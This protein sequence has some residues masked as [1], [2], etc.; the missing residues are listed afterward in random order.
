VS[1][2]GQEDANQN[3]VG[4]ACETAEPPEPLETVNVSEVSGNILVKLP[5]VQ[6]FVPLG[7][8][9]Q[10]PL[11]STIDARNGK[12]RLF[13]ARGGGVGRVVPGIGPA[14]AGGLE[15]QSA[16]FGSGMFKVGQQQ[17][18]AKLITRI[19]LTGGNFSQCRSGGTSPVKRVRRIQAVGEGSFSTK[20]R[21]GTATASSSTATT[22]WNTVDQCNGTLVKA[23]EGRLVVH[24][25]ARDRTIRLKAGERFLIRKSA[26]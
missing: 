24:D 7:P 8:E 22:S 9:V 18:Q 6:G 19:D 11:G 4:D 25:L 15:L 2:P 3:D 12:V 10:I 23:R 13:A 1:N 20:G 21:Y 26:G 14:R 17:Q 5:G 16:V